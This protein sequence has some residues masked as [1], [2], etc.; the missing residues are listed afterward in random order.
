MGKVVR[1]RTPLRAS[2]CQLNAQRDLGLLASGT[3]QLLATTGR[4]RKRS[5]VR[6][7]IRPFYFVRDRERNGL[8]CKST[9]E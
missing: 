4:W 6:K 7:S 8:T 5:D 1:I 2:P 9:H 3:A